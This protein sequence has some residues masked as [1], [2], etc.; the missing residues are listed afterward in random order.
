[1]DE[2]DSYWSVGG[3]IAIAALSPAL[4]V[5]SSVGAIVL[6]P[7]HVKQVWPMFSELRQPTF[8]RVGFLA[9]RRLD[10][11][12]L[13]YAEFA[14]AVSAEADARNQAC[15]VVRTSTFIRLL[16]VGK[17]SLGLVLAA[18]RSTALDSLLATT[19]PDLCV[20]GVLRGPT[21]VAVGSA[22]FAMAFLDGPGRRGGSHEWGVT[23]L[24]WEDGLFWLH[25]EARS[26]LPAMQ[27]FYRF[28]E[29]DQTRVEL[30]GHDDD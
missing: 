7:G 4:R 5:P 20:P 2:S 28:V 21:V 16:V 23:Y 15:V 25:T 6:R 30:L 24:G 27:W 26:S 17:D 1:M 29:V 13:R 10:P 18:A 9:E 14:E 8:T 22:S 3:N 19:R 11:R 12:T